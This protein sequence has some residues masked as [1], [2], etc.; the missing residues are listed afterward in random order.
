M[1]KWLIAIVTL[2]LLVA[3]DAGIAKR[4]AQ[5]ASGTRVLLEV[6]PVDPRAL[7]QGD[8]MALSFRLVRD[9]FPDRVAIP[10]YADGRIVVTQDERGVGHFTRFD[11][12]T[13]L[14]DHQVRLRYRVRAGDVKFATNAYF[15]EEG[16]G[17][18]FAGA[19]YA[20]FRVADDGEMILTLLRD[21][22]LG[23]LKLQPR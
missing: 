12:G 22:D 21:K 1:R 8:F 13:P 10:D 5:L 15:F 3:V 20:E 6:V 2:V 11:D 17:A 7:M 16:H 4:E 18:D 19:R 14:A 9:A 23:E